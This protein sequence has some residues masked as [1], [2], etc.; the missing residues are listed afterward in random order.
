[1]IGDILVHKGV[2]SD[3]DIVS[4]G[5][6]T[7]DRRVDSEINSVTNGRNALSMTPVFLADGAALMD[8]NVTTQLRPSV[9]R[10]AVRVT[11][12]EACANLS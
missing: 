7:C 6:P 10:N 3:K 8:V 1:M 12:V 2:R 11:N 4:N 5:H 9:N